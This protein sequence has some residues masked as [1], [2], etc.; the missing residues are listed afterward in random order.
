MELKVL[1][2]V[3]GGLETLSFQLPNG[4]LVPAHFHVTEVG[5]VNK[6]Y[7]DCGGTFR[8]EAKVN[9]QLWEANDYDHRLHPEKFLAIIKL[10]EEQ[11]GIG[12]AP[13][14]VEYQGE[15]IEVYDLAFEENQLQLVSKFTNCLAPD[16]CGVEESKPKLN[17]RSIGDSSNTCTPGSGCC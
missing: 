3:L 16:K 7:I 8:D 9:L 2:E 12:N 10:A 5:V 17:L 14:E 1:K 13:V 11:L 4:Q 15:T 6:K